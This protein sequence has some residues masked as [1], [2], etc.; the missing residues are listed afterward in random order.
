MM[1]D[2]DRVGESMKK[3]RRFLKKISIFVSVLLIALIVVVG[4]HKTGIYRFDFVRDFYKKI[5]FQLTT[6][7]LNIPQ[8]ALSFSVY[9][10]ENDEYLFYEGEGQLPTVASLAKLFVIDYALQRVE[11]DDVV[12]VNQEVLDLVPAGSSV[13]DLQVG[14]YT[15]KQLMQGMLVPSGNDAAYALAYHIAKNDMGSGYSAI[16]YIHY[17]MSLLSEYLIEQGYSNTHLYEDPSGASMQADTNLDDVNRVALKL[18]NYD[19]VRECIGESTF[20]I[21]TSQGEITWENTNKLLDK[22]SPFYNE[23]IVGM[24]TGTMAS[25]YSVVAIYEEDGKEYLITCLAARSDEG[26][27]RAVQSAINIYID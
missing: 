21:Q 24:K 4:L 15:V 1:L 19:F 10:I 5:S 16:E 9:D 18:L 17:F 27:Y 23:K 8:D 14:E 3:S 26:R 6:T 20:T 2:I 22:H 7:E 13:A 25:S 11:L 12:I